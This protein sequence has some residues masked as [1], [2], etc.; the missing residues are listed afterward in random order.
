MKSFVMFFALC[1][2]FTAQSQILK[3]T[4]YDYQK[5]KVESVYYVNSLGQNNGL[6]KK[7]DSQG[8]KGIELN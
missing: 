6:Y 7:Y 3:K 4:Y 2:V 1:V 8:A 5:I